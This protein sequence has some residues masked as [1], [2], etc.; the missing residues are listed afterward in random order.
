MNCEI[1]NAGLGCDITINDLSLL[2]SGGSSRINHVEH[3]HPQ[4]EIPKLL[5]NSNKANR[6]LNWK[7]EVSLEEGIR[8]TREW[9]QNG[10]LA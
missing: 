5:C 6:I 3:I 1:V 8:R 10:G 9:I 2:I 7:P 4:S